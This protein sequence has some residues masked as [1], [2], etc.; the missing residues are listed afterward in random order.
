MKNVFKLLTLIAVFGFLTTS[1]SNDNDDDTTPP[2]VSLGDYANGI[3]VTAEGGPASVSY[4]SND[5]STSENNIYFN[6]NNEELGVYLQSM[7]FNDNKGYIV[8]DNVNTVVVVGRYSFIKEG[9][10]SDGLNRPRYIAF[11]NGI[12]YVT[13][14]G[15]P[16]DSSDDFVAV[17]DLSTNMVIN[18]I[19]V[20][21]GPEQIIAVG[22]KLYVSH[23]GGYSVN[24]I[25]SVIDVTNS[26]VNTIVV[27]DMPDEMII[28]NSGQL[29]V[30]CEGKP[31][32]T[33]DET[34]AS[35]S[36]IDLSSNTVIETL[37][38][39]DGVHP[40]AMGYTNG[41]V[42]YQSNNEVFELSDS[43]STVPS[44]AILTLD[45]TTPYGMAVKNDKLYVTDAK[46]YASLSDLIIYDLNTKSIVNTFEVG[47]NAS[48]I[49]FN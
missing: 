36:K 23:K 37:S 39:A 5:Y 14:W 48:K 8:S 4:I 35:I 20:G 43:A 11:S 29:V 13:N 28:N 40:S 12:G 24:N 7:G 19:P 16:Y 2:V 6:V 21:E 32:W 15:D 33:G 31:A 25:I 17:V 38:F 49:Y 34:L 1:C 3:L 45:A 30:L 46:D 44:S 10:I 18:T 41:K 47:L 42:Y 9:S 22:N 26:T 27:N